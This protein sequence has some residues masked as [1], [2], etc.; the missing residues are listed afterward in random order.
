MSHKKLL[1]KKCIRKGGRNSKYDFIINLYYVDEIIVKKIE[2]KYNS[3]SIKSL[4]QFLSLYSNFRLYSDKTVIQY[5][6]FFYDYY[7]EEISDLANIKIPDKKQYLKYVHQTNYDKLSWF[8]EMKER[9]T[10]K[11]FV[12][13]KKRDC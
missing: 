5:D 10:D 6:H 2:F 3:N 9:E 1:A 11:A 8:S 12:K 13:A 4:P 7:V